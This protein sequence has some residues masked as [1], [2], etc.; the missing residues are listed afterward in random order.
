MGVAAVVR[1]APDKGALS[2]GPYRE[3]RSAFRPRGASTLAPYSVP[4]ED[5]SGLRSVL[6][7]VN[8]W[9]Y[10]RKLIPKEA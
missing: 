6:V 7:R 5:G 2:A 9:R 1:F 3:L 10:R 4:S 8:I